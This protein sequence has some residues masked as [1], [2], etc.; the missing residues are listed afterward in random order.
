MF[1]NLFFVSILWAM[2]KSMSLIRG[3]G[4]F[5]FRSMMFF[6]WGGVWR[7]EGVFAVFVSFEFRE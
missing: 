2:S 1:L 4:T 5:L 6:G 7:C 3:L